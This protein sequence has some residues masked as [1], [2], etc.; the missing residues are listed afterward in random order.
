MR[1]REKMRITKQVYSFFAYFLCISIT[2]SLWSPQVVSAAISQESKKSN[3][4]HPIQENPETFAPPSLNEEIVNLS[5]SLPDIQEMDAPSLF[6][7]PLSV[8]RIQ[9]AYDSAS[10][11]DNTM[12]ITVTIRN[13]LPPVNL[14]TIPDTATLTETLDIIKAVDYVN[15]PNTIHNVVLA[16][17][18]LSGTTFLNSM[19][20]AD[21]NGDDV[22][23]SIGDIPPLTSIDVTLELSVSE[24][25]D[26]VDLDTGVTAWATLHG[27]MVSATAA[28]I[29][30]VPQD[31]SQWL[32]STID[33][34]RYD[35]HMLTKL[36]EVGTTASDI[37]AYAQ[38]IGFE[39]YDGSLRGTRGTLWSDAGNSADQASLMIAM[40]RASG[41]PARYQHGELFESE[42][43][44]LINSMFPRVGARGGVVRADVVTSNPVEDPRLLETVS[45]H[46]WVEAFVP[47]QGWLAFDP[48][49][50]G[51]AV[52]DI[53]ATNLAAPLAELPDSVRHKVTV[54]LKAE[55]YHPLNVG[56][57]IQG[58]EQSVVLE[59][60]LR[61]VEVIGETATIN[62]I[63]N[64]SAQGG[65]IF[66]NIHTIYTPFLVLGE[67]DSERVI[68]GESYQDLL[69][70]FPLGTVMTTGGW[71]E[72][73]VQYPDG[74][75]RSNELYERQLF[76]RVGYELRNAGTGGLAQIDLSDL[77]STPAVGAHSSYSF[78]LAPSVV[79][80]DA[81]NLRFGDM[82]TAATTAQAAAQSVQDILAQG[83]PS[84]S[85]LPILREAAKQ[86]SRGTLLGQTTHLLAF[87]SV[88]DLSSSQLGRSSLV[89]GYYDS[90]RIL[91]LSW[92]GSADDESV[93]VQFDLRRNKMKTVVYPGQTWTGLQ[94]FNFAR[95][96]T[97]ASIEGVL[98]ERF[99]GQDVK[100]V[101]HVMQEV[102]RLGIPMQVITGMNKIDLANLPI[103]GEAKARI[104]DVLID[105]A[106]MVIVP[107][108]MVVLG[109]GETIGWYE[110][111]MINGETIDTMENGQHTAVV[112]YSMMLSSSITEV[113]FAI[114]GY[115]Q[116]F[117]AYTFAFMGEI[118]SYMPFTTV[119]LKTAWEQSIADA[120]TTVTAIADNF[121][122]ALNIVND[123]FEIENPPDAVGWID[124]YFNGTGYGGSI[125]IDLGS[126]SPAL[127]EM[128]DLLDSPPP[129]PVL[130]VAGELEPDED[131]GPPELPDPSEGFL[132][133][134][135]G[136]LSQE[137]LDDWTLSLELDIGGFVAGANFA[138]TVINNQVD[139][140]IPTAY[141]SR[142]ILEF[143]EESAVAKEVTVAG[144]G[145]GVAVDEALAV[146]SSYVGGGGAWGYESVGSS[147]AEF[148]TL[149]SPSISSS[150]GSGTLTLTTP[151]VV[152]T[153]VATVSA[154]GGEGSHGF[155]AP[156]STGVAHGS[157]WRD[158]TV[159]LASGF[160]YTVNHAVGMLEDTLIDEMGFD[161]T[162]NET[163]SLSGDGATAAGSFV[164]DIDG[165]LT[166][167]GLI[168]APTSANP[169]GLAF[170]TFDGSFDI[171][172][173]GGT[174]TVVLNGSGERFVLELSAVQSTILPL[175]T[176]G[177]SAEIDSNVTADY[178]LLA[179][180]PGGWTAE[181][182]N[183]GDIDLT[184]PL[185]TPPD[186]YD[187]RIVAQSLTRPDVMLH[188]T[189]AVTVLQ[190]DDVAINIDPDLTHTV[191]WGEP[192]TDNP[193]ANN[194][195]IQLTDSAFDVSVHNTSSIPREFTVEITGVPTDWIVFDGQP[196]NTTATVYLQPD[197]IGIFGL[198]ISPPE[199]TLP[200]AGTSLGIDASVT[201]VDNPAVTD[202]ASA[203]FTMPSAAY[204]YVRSAPR[205]QYV[206]V[207]QLPQVDIL[208]A[209]VGNADGSFPLTA[210]VQSLDGSN[211]LS[212]SPSS[213]AV[214]VS[215]GMTE[216]T[217]LEIDTTNALVGG[218]YYV[219][220]VIENGPYL[221]KTTN[222]LE[223][224]SEETGCLYLTA[225]ASLSY[226]SILSASLVQLGNDVNDL[227]AD[228]ASTSALADVE[229]TFDIVLALF[230]P[231]V[232]TTS[233]EAVANN[234]P[235][236]LSD[237]CAEIDPI[238]AEMAI[239]S[240]TA[241][242]ARIVP[243]A[244]TSLVSEPITYTLQIDNRSDSPTTFAITTTILGV[245]ETM[246]VT[247]STDTT[248]EIDLI[249][250]PTQL[251]GSIISAE[252][253]P[254][255]PN[256][257]PL[258]SAKQTPTASLNAVDSLLTITSV[259][260]DP[261]FVEP[262]ISD[263]DL[264][265]QLVNIANRPFDATASISIIS[266][267]NGTTQYT[268]TV[269]LSISPFDATTYDLGTVNT[270]DWQE[271]GYQIN[272]DL[273]DS[274]G[275]LIPTAQGQGSLTV[276][277]SLIAEI[278]LSETILPPGTSNI[279]AEIAT[280]LTQ[281]GQVGG[282]TGIVITDALSVDSIANVGNNNHTGGV[283]LTLDA[284]TYDLI[285]ED[286]AYQ[287]APDLNWFGSVR[288]SVVYTTT[289]AKEY[290]IGYGADFHFNGA[291]TS[292][293]ATS[294]NKGQRARLYLP[295]AAT[296]YFWIPDTNGADNLGEMIMSV[297][298]L[299]DASDD[300]NRKVEGALGHS[301]PHQSSET[302]AFDNWSNDNGCLACHVQAQ[303]LLSADAVQQKIDPDL[304]DKRFM[305]LIQQNIIGSIADSGVIDNGGWSIP[306]TTFALWA[307][308]E[309][310]NLL[311]TNTTALNDTPQTPGI[312]RY[313]ENHPNIRFNDAPFNQSLAWTRFTSNDAS[314]YRYTRAN[315]PDNTVSLTF[316]GSW[317]GVGFLGNT[318]AGQVEVTIDG[319][320]YGIVDTYRRQLTH[321][322]EYYTLD[323]GGTHTITLTSLDENNPFSSNTYIHFDFF[324]VWDGTTMPDGVFQER[325]DRIH[326]S[327]NWTPTYD[328]PAATDGTWLRNGSNAW[329]MFTGDS[330]GINALGY[331][332]TGEVEL[333]IDGNL[334]DQ[335][336]LYNQST[337]S[338]TIS[339][340]GLGD[341]PHVLH[342]KNYRG[343]ANFDAFFT[344]SVAP[345]EDPDTTITPFFRYEEDDPRLLYNGVPFDETVSNWVS[346]QNNFYSDGYIAYTDGIDNTISLTFD[347]EWVALGF[348]ETTTG[349]IV[350]VEIDGV[351]QPDIDTYS[352]RADTGYETYALSPGTHTI[353]LRNSSERNEFSS[354]NRIHLDFIDVWDGTDISDGM[355][356]ENDEHIYTS[357]N[358]R[359]W[360][361]AVPSEGRAEIDGTE[362]WFPFTGDS[363]SVQTVADTWAGEVAI[364]I[365]GI[366]QGLFSLYATE[367]TTRT[368]SFDGLTDGVHVVSISQ[369]R[370]R[371]NIDKF[372]TP[373]V[374]PSDIP[375]LDIG[376][377]RIEEDNPT[378]LYN[379]VPLTETSTTWVEWQNSSLLSDGYA[380]YTD[381]ISNTVELTFEGEWVGVGFREGSNGG[382]VEVFIDGVRQ[383][384][385]DT[386]SPYGSSEYE[387]YSGLGAG[388]HT[389]LLRNSSERN[390]LSSR[391]RIH[392]DFIDVWDGTPLPTG[393]IEEDVLQVYSTWNWSN[394][395]NAVASDGHARIDGTQRW[396]PFAGESV[397]YRA[398]GGTWAG[399]VAIR[400]DGELQGYY[401][402]YA[403]ETTTKTFTFDG[404]TDEAH[405]LSVEKHRGRATVDGF[406]VPG[407]VPNDNPPPLG[408]VHR[409]EEDDPTVLYNGA[410]WYESP[411]WA[412]FDRTEASDRYAIYTDAV[413][414]TIGMSFE[415]ERIGVGTIGYNN[416]GTVRVVIDGVDRGTIDTYSAV[417]NESQVTYFDV[418]AGSHTI[419]LTNL[420]DANPSSSS[421]RIHFDYFEVWDGGSLPQGTFQT[422]D[423]RVW[424]TYNWNLAERSV[425]SD[426]IISLDGSRMWFSF[427]DDS[428]TVQLYGNTWTGVVEVLIDGVSQGVYTTTA[429]TETVLPLDFTGLGAGAHTML[430]RPVSGRAAID[431]FV[432]P[433][434]APMRSAERAVID[435]GSLV[436]T[437]EP[438]VLD[439][440]EPAVTEERYVETADRERST[441]LDIAVTRTYTEGLVAMADYLITQ[442]GSDGLWPAN[443]GSSSVSNVF[444][445]DVGGANGQHS[446]MTAYNMVSMGKL[447]ELTGDSAYLDSL[448]LGAAAL[449]TLPFSRTHSVA[450]H[451]MIGLDAALDHVEGAA[452]QADVINT[453]LAIDDY[454]REHQQADG[455]WGVSETITET[456][457]LPTAS[458]LYALTLLEPSSND[459]VITSAADYLLE[460][461]RVDG[462]WSSRYHQNNNSPLLAT[463]W[464]NISLPY[465]FE[466]LSSF[467]VFIDHYVPDGVAVVDGSVVPPATV[468]PLVG[469]SL[470]EW[471][472]VLVGDTTEQ[473]VSYEMTVADLQPGEVLQV[474]NGSVVDYVSASGQSSI[475]LPP[476]FVM[477]GHLADLVPD[478]QVGSPGETVVFDVILENL[479]DAA[480]LYVLDVVG[481][482]AEWVDLP[483]SV[484]MPA[485]GSV[486]VQLGVS[487]PEFVDLGAYDFAV[488]VENQAG[489]SELVAG[490]LRVVQGIEVAVSPVL[491]TAVGGSVVTYTVTVT[492]PAGSMQTFGLSADGF[493]GI[494]VTLPATVDV[495][496]NGSISVDL[497]LIAPPQ[498]GANLFEVIATANNVV[499]SA[500]AGVLVLDDREVKVMMSPDIQVM[501]PGVATVYDVTVTNL[502]LTND[503]YDLLVDVPAGWSAVFDV[504][505]ETIDS[506]ALPPHLFN[507]FTVS[508]IVTPP[509]D[510]SVGDYPVS[511][512][513]RS[514]EVGAVSDSA[515]AMASILGAGVELEL[516][517]SV[518]MI[519]PNETGVWNVVVTNTGS[520]T[521]TFVLSAT[522]LLAGAGVFSAE[523]ITLAPNESQAVQMT[524]SGFETL[525]LSD[526]IVG[527][528][529]QSQAQAEITANDSGNL[530]LTPFE[531][532]QV[533]W[534]PDIQGTAELTPVEYTLVLTNTGNVGAVY[535]L[536]FVAPFLTI[537]S[538][539]DQLYIAPQTTV[540][541]LVTVT[542]SGLGTFD[543]EVLAESTTSDVTGEDTAQLV[544]SMPSSVHSTNY[545][546]EYIA[547]QSLLFIL[548]FGSLILGTFMLRSRLRVH[549][550]DGLER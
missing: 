431:A 511:V 17:T 348:H 233:L 46:W 527:A 39:A 327:H 176:T 439:N 334:L 410:P 118:M 85:D 467:D 251:G 165:S 1:E 64:A 405:V 247:V 443:L 389:I 384:D 449:T 267:D 484:A 160:T 27:R 20:P 222:V 168:F 455:G 492:N 478:V 355:F 423:D 141:H 332:G 485:A 82:V 132:V 84:D 195:Q 339:Y 240:E 33:A 172:D 457:V 100:S 433:A 402:L 464:V 34:N 243:G 499:D 73:E 386:Y 174:D 5:E 315:S 241:F 89:K 489:G 436:E 535:D 319:V 155:Y 293:E 112:E 359:E 70:N 429:S 377:E 138:V 124:A 145:G 307:L 96:V 261:P 237:I 209:N 274:A 288:A 41:I 328:Q 537:S 471:E 372:I 403:T 232:D 282:E 470:Y 338:R 272:V 432:A 523:T 263:T 191:P 370:G 36:S 525:A 440:V 225:A 501:G 45:D 496:A 244:Y 488:L 494:S 28:P 190:I 265:L 78:L 170:H 69:T 125:S 503:V 95:G 434:G 497:I 63:V 30:L 236:S 421:R 98:M 270:S 411:G 115:F 404:L 505:G 529:A 71:L 336:D 220:T 462:F 409:Y 353:I 60:T 477:A 512:T 491:T 81:I 438:A 88:S 59:H 320:S 280:Y 159:E 14:P 468:T 459:P 483:V 213:A 308:A 346:A 234:L 255:D 424:R 276:G 48:T 130:C 13:T 416:G 149:S 329:F 183:S 44:D 412:F 122:I 226:D 214:A 388:T 91:A 166:D 344:P 218:R 543:F 129:D 310:P 482:P 509:S 49:I 196:G 395:E 391:N 318:N 103:S 285:I 502:G 151:S 239:L 363:V 513:A 323:T 382:I 110:I 374:P 357:W 301:L 545:N 376:F 246:T 480:D 185:G 358:W 127:D 337:I 333:F 481:L 401:D 61:T 72:F 182:S 55:Q 304:P 216:T 284:G 204:G 533:E 177:F 15:D 126:I 117:A 366:D 447:Y 396:F 163:V 330:V 445:N 256:N 62:H 526:Y 211:S 547:G 47:G 186:T 219:E 298:Q 9:S 490:V 383:P 67:G 171:T 380:Y 349:G 531:A 40:L 466:V 331:T 461:Q 463:T 279:Q 178:R 193:S 238:T 180:V 140:P 184:P 109:G 446:S 506:V 450:I 419:E 342:M 548:L 326:T 397:S 154:S 540:S 105:P 420:S 454:L 451:H 173:A 97:D 444:W 458:A 114:V 161:F 42:K 269:P 392:F 10:L 189:H 322:S 131:E 498:G 408:S 245:A 113:A 507:A 66:S 249:A 107:S 254:L 235:A 539:F 2:L 542:P 373:S 24:T 550:R 142:S 79:S 486:A 519:A 517:P 473:V 108:A 390:P 394:W 534:Q 94:A 368:F 12:V 200:S 147:S 43:A 292:F 7:N 275:N 215:A 360:L 57:P 321:F 354:R 508:L 325:T 311:D 422:T 300:R 21:A 472:Y 206:T 75:G 341:G 202:S 313:E 99:S 316:D 258:V 179:F 417:A 495:P 203:T 544:V 289:V 268:D 362:K 35:T 286:G 199:G 230:P 37:F 460:A 187:I 453:M 427:T 296:V 128:D 197:E 217:V 335:Y 399:E 93:L 92:E 38:T 19:P 32:I 530:I 65:L 137:D 393:D 150:I 194:G 18:L 227:V 123:C 260:A 257:Q 515:E 524:A 11:T 306:N 76:D 309:S 162:S 104:S 157:Q 152:N 469:D 250:T 86:I 520:E 116:G 201:A 158:V 351:R 144:S 345:F 538:E 398:I 312:F 164:T 6:D 546:T 367:A 448:T 4:V 210:S 136:G 406:V 375:S 522:G 29:K 77:G 361:N 252:I 283:P 514:Q 52:G 83:D 387:V 111:D 50:P 521:D 487:V 58:L 356:E 435:A 324:D 212:V 74:S 120:Q 266:V 253:V 264:T 428:A 229:S 518:L 385:I 536:S 476:Q 224:V 295:D 479:A 442:Q 205:L 175:E 400:I 143:E 23:W 528:T 281:S 425:A 198:Y 290:Y 8:S 287:I 314:S 68:E 302:L 231:S 532:L 371:A 51:A 317:I 25:D 278:S 414:N 259:T 106:K 242:W 475:V 101:Y 53:F 500:E 3:E 181:I 291:A 223:I 297:T 139:P 248:G 365:D 541:I 378:L 188:T 549:K 418:S 415:G 80:T 430:V 22:L 493:E 90:P 119:D 207:D 504:N 26:F 369:Y 192:I 146:V 343:N 273:L 31:M 228:P 121:N 350:E 456:D 271:G 262:T 135:G 294:L 303:G 102:E 221:P 169:N 148:A 133:R 452:L 277:Q 208:I 299:Y 426:G 167:A 437:V 364:R 379:G 156:A 352:P 340:E 134:P 413:S 56:G 381:Q 465:V 441:E 87:A 510:A 407:V 474:T 153:T 347:G 305:Q 516:L 54:R 16:D